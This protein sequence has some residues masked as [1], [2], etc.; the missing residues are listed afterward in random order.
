MASCRSVSSAPWPVVVLL[1][2]LLLHVLLFGLVE[3]GV[4]Q[5]ERFEYLVLDGPHIGLE[6]PL[7]CVHQEPAE[8]GVLVTATAGT[9]STAA[10]VFM[11]GFF[12][13][14]PLTL[15]YGFFI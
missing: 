12:F 10:T 6:S 4:E 5:L 9:A 8:V 2:L 3:L 14:Q 11:L 15:K 13:R 7:H 1:L